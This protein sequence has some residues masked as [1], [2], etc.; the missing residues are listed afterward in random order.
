M[1]AVSW[2]CKYWGHVIIGLITGEIGCT[3]VFK[4]YKDKDDPWVR[5]FPG[6]MINIMFCSHLK[7]YYTPGVT[8]TVAPPSV[9]LWY[10]PIPKHC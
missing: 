7:C 8:C 10:R 1:Y 2:Q 3:T 9:G 6:L 5:G 4:T